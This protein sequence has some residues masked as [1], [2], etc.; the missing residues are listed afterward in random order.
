MIVPN[1]A[2]E[3]PFLEVALPLP[4]RTLFTYARP[5]DLRPSAGMRVMVPFRNRRMTGYVVAGADAAPAGVKARPIID[6]LDEAPLFNAEQLELYRWIAR[7][8][9]ESLG[10]VI[11]AALPAGPRR[12]SGPLIWRQNWGSIFNEF[13]SAPSVANS[14]SKEYV[15]RRIYT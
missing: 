1:P 3:T 8:Y 9:H 11:R 13:C 7:Y 4:L 12:P 5:A 10:E 6:V 15:L 2:L 14:R